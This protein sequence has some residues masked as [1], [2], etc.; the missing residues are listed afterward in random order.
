MCALLLA[1]AAALLC[2]QG[3]ILLVGGGSENKNSWSDR[4]YR[5]L[6]Q[7]A[8]NRKILVLNYADTTTFFTGYFPWLSPCTVRNL[9]IT[10]RTAANDSATYRMIL[11]YDGIFLR[12]GDQ[13]QYISRWQGTLT[14][15][16]LRQVYARGG[17]IGGTSAGAAVLSGVIF[18]AHVASVDP[19]EA[20]RSP[21]SSGISFT[22][23]FL[24]LLPGTI[25]DT[26]FHERGRIGRLPAMLT[27]RL[28][29]NGDQLIGLG[30]DSESAIGI[31][32]LG[33]A[34]AL[35]GGVVT[36]LRWAGDTR[37]DY[38]A[39]RA[40]SGAGFQFD[41]L[42]DSFRI[43]LTTGIITPA[44]S[45]SAFIPD[46]ITAPPGTVIID[47]SGLAAD[48]S[49]PGGSLET[50]RAKTNGID[51]LVVV[52]SATSTTQ[53][54]SVAAV[55][56]SLGSPASVVGLDESRRGDAG[57]AGTLT[58]AAGFVLIGNTPDSC[59]RILS[60]DAA[61][62][63]AFWG[64]VNG[65]APVAC[66]SDDAMLAGSVAVGSLY[67]DLYSA[68]K[69]YLRIL[70]GLKLI[71]GA[72]VMPRIYENTDYIES[73]FCGMFWE[74]GMASAPLGILLDN[75]STVV[76]TNG[77]ITAAGAT[78]V[79]VVDARTATMRGFPSWK[80]GVSYNPR[81]NAAFLGARLHL[82]RAGETLDITN[83][84]VTGAVHE[85]GAVP[86]RMLLEP[87]VPNPFNPQ[88]T[89]GYTLDRAGMVELRIFDLLGREV[90]TLVSG[91]QSPG[92]HRVLWNAGRSPS[93]VY[94]CRL[95]FQP[96]GSAGDERTDV[97]SMVLIR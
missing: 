87:N 67:K 10:S 84:V 19:R 35:G 12:G 28:R 60:V 94:F 40:F 43:N 96:A 6:V 3:K 77:V 69:G 59:A 66:L 82:L 41:Q 85:T 97:R 65:G 8:P 90:A 25:S 46:S 73:R 95:T 62:G 56:R 75:A 27:K 11:E 18:D 5:W 44:A 39:G 37:A 91:M 17:V 34:E 80:Y 1:S 45:A 30:V 29:E 42:T 36:V 93:G 51:T 15:Q 71:R 20:L 48:W 9:A 31:D 7:Q 79:M 74:M 4:P 68:Y 89:I 16:A 83:G 54:E 33:M 47:G 72:V 58:G 38:T 55:L 21:V 13:W 26:H 22:D 23:D 63:Q 52:T 50:I 70:P 32:S 53:A 78:P 86:R 24:Q 76:M 57:T 49:A 14:E 88:T 92:R 64:R 2:G 61:S 81:Q